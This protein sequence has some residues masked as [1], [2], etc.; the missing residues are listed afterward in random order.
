[1]SQELRTVVVNLKSLDQD[2]EDP[3]IAGGGD[4]SGR[5]LRIIFSQEAYAQLTPETKVYLSWHH[6]EQDVSGLNVFTKVNDKPPIWEI[7][8]P[9]NMLME[10]NAT[11]CIKLVDDIS[12]SQSSNFIVHI[13]KDPDD[14]SHFVVSDDYSI[15]QQA[16]IEM[17]TAV[18]NVN[19]VIDRANEKME[20]FDE[21]KEKIDTAYDMAKDALDLIE[22]RTTATGVVII[23]Y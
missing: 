14:G 19:E 18:D 22:E 6:E 17:N 15:F 1:M 10:G 21:M 5:T 13:L 7:K 8:Y 23:D 9:R 11:C 2:I 20:Q 4:A 3:I 16:V 12:I